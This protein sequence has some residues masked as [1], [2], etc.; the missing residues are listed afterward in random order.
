MP[1]LNFVTTVDDVSR[2]LGQVAS[3]SQCCTTNE[4]RVVSAAQ[5]GHCASIRLHCPNRNHAAIDWTSS[6]RVRFSALTGGGE[7][8]EAEDYLLN[9]KLCHAV[10]AS[11]TNRHKQWQLEIFCLTIEMLCFYKLLPSNLL[12]SVETKI[13]SC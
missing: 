4:L 12:I 9:V 7:I 6:P 3:H 8:E 1:N 13:V 2:L 10:T 5:K 11:G